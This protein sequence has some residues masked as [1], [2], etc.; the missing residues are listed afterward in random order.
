MTIAV[1]L[2][3]PVPEDWISGSRMQTGANLRVT[4]DT[5]LVGRLRAQRLAEVLQA[6]QRGRQPASGRPK[7]ILKLYP[8]ADAPAPAGTARKQMHAPLDGSKTRIPWFLLASLA[9]AVAD[10]YRR[11]RSSIAA[12]LDRDVDS[13][14]VQLRS[15]RDRT[16]KKRLADALQTALHADENLEAEIAKRINAKIAHSDQPYSRYVDSID[17]LAS[18]ALSNGGGR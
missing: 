5:A 10:E 18:P 7:Y 4:E 12:Q 15:T 6:P 8:N 16:E 11:Q 2:K 17:W 13:L 1:A 9:E 14:E 3:E